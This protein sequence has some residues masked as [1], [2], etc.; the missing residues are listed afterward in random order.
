VWRAD[1]ARFAAFLARFVVGFV[2]RKTRQGA[3]KRKSRIRDDAMSLLIRLLVS[4]AKQTQ[5]MGQLRRRSAAVERR[6]VRRFGGVA[7]VAKRPAVW[8]ACASR[9]AAE[10]L[11]GGDFGTGFAICERLLFRRT[12]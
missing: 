9:N 1:S 12:T 6:A 3:F 2:D 8:R 4:L 10:V 11:R 5:Q 7:Y